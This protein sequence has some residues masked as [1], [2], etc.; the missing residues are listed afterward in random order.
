MSADTITDP[1]G[2]QWLLR[3]GCSRHPLSS[4]DA[5]PVGGAPTR[6]NECCPVC[7]RY[8]RFHATDERCPS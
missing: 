1:E 3:C 5:D 4:H 7:H 8:L 2:H 6:R